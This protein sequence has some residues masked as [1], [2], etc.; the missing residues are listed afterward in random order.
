MLVPFAVALLFL[1]R[2]GVS[3]NPTLNLQVEVYYFFSVVFGFFASY[4]IIFRQNLVFY[5]VRF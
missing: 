3:N 1:P 5:A 4:C 2:W